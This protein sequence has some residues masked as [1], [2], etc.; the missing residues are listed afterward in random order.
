LVERLICNEEV[1]GSN[2]VGSTDDSKTFT[3]E[4]FLR[5]GGRRHVFIE[6]KTAEPGSWNFLCVDTKNI[7]DHKAN[8]YLYEC[9]YIWR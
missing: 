4:S 1:T 3:S 2:P 5:C 7:P 9:R 8:I 6:I